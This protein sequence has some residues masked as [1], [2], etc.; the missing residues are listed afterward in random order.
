MKKKLSEAYARGMTVNERLF[1]YRLGLT[2]I[3]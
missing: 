3:V 2:G 1:T